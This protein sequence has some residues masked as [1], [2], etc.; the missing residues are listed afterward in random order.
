MTAQLPA[1]RAH[2]YLALVDVAG[3][4]AVDELAGGH[5][6]RPVAEVAARRVDAPQDEAVLALVEADTAVPRLGNL[7]REQDAVRL[8]AWESPPERQDSKPIPSPL[9]TSPFHRG[10]LHEDLIS[11]DDDTKVFGFLSVSMMLPFVVSFHPL[12]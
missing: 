8:R 4:R 10:R 2:P 12:N 3:E 5:V 6:S 7:R 11:C 1:L 9:P